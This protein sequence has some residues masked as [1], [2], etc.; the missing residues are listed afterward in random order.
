LFTLTDI[1]Y[2]S[3][4]IK[5]IT[6]QNIKLLLQGTQSPR[7]VGHPSRGSCALLMPALELVNTTVV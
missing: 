6:S 5:A 1:V 2:F 3:L 4:L 7:E